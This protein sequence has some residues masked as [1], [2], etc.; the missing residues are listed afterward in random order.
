MEGIGGTLLRLLDEHSDLA[1]FLL[2]FM[3]ESGIPLPLPGDLVML[4]AG[5]R[6]AEGKSVAVLSLAIMEAATLL[7]STI[8]Y[9]L[10]R[11][12]GRPMLYRYGKFLHLELD[13]LER[14]EDFLRRHGPLAIVLGRVI[15]GLR[16]PTSLAAGV[17]G[18]PYP[19]FLP[20][21]AIGSFAYILFYFLL[22]YFFGPNV[23]RAIEGPHF[24]LRFVWLLL[25]MGAVVAAYVAIRRSAHLDRALP[26]LREPVRLETALMAGLLATATSTLVMDLLLSG[27]IAVG[28]I[29]PAEALFTLFQGLQPHFGPRPTIELWALAIAGYVALH[30]GWALLYAHVARWLPGPDWLGGLL[31]ALLPLAFA[32]LVLLPAL[33]AGPLGLHLGAGLLPLAGEVLRNAAYGVSLATGYTLLNRARLA[34][35]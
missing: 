17:F 1:L 7:G 28:E 24:Q 15:P 27:V 4:L 2:L 32:A 6:A 33:G 34:A 18:V 35:D 5:V 21:L 9:T 26:G 25:G 10:A 20:A 12:G 16:I 14:A 8:L 19:V 30:L 23:L 3:E 13:K 11:R 29:R 31:F 22:G